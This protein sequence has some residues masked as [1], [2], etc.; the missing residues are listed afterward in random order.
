MKKNAPFF[1]GLQ[2]RK[3]NFVERDPEIFISFHNGTRVDIRGYSKKKFRVEFWLDNK[4]EYADEIQSGMFA[5][6]NKRYRLPWKVKVLEG[7]KVIVEKSVKDLKGKRVH[8]YLDSSSLGDNLAW[9]PQ[10]E[11]FRE[12][13]GCHLVLTTFFNHLFREQYREIEWNDPGTALHDIHVMYSIGYHVGEDRFN[14]IPVDP[15]TVPLGRVPCEILGIPYEE[16]RPLLK[17]GFQRPIKD[18]YVCIAT[19]STAGAKLWHREYAWEDIIEHLNSKGIRVVLIQ[20][21]ESSLSNVIDMTGDRP[22]EERMAVLE[23]CEMFIGLGSGLSWLAWGMEKPVV[24]VSGFSEAFAEFQLDCER[25][26]NPDVCHGCWND[27]NHV[28]DKGDWNWCPRQ[29]DT[30]RQ[31]ECTKKISAIRVIRAIDKILSN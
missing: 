20:K 19:M 14:K 17:K 10:I 27:V 30:P 15:R 16:V 2:K 5:A 1:E 22:L 24:L 9:M 7:K 6:P 18:K 23:H 21:E 8:V 29:K 25:I 3:E 11:R 13:T 4:L 12:I 28:F 26:I 31:F